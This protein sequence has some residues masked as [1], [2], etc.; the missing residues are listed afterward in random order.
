MPKDNVIIIIVKFLFIINLGCS[1]PLAIY[2][3]NTILESYIFK[4]IKTK[5]STA[6]KWI[7]NFS[8]FLVVA[9]SVYLAVVLASKLDK[10]LSLLGALLCAPLAFTMPTLCH[11]KLLA[12]TKAQKIEDMLI[13]GLSFVILVFCTIQ[14]IEGWNK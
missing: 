4:C 11:F 8:R 6:R 5:N 7:K 12:T 14:S 9:L 13:V 3:V 10:F 1:Y 2:P